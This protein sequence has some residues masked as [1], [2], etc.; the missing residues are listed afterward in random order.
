MKR[1]AYLAICLAVLALSL[2]AYAAEPSVELGKKLFNDPALGTNGKTCATCHPSEK[3]V[4]EL[5]ARGT[6]FGGKAKMLEQAINFCITGPLEGKAL[7]EDSSEARS[8]AMYMN[9]LAK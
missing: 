2:T 7:P 9:S 6:W 8:I 4:G 3:K 1:I 5:A